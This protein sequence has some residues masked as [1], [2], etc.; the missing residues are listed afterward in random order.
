MSPLTQC[1]AWQDLINHRSEVSCLHLK[2]LFCN[3]PDRFRKFSFELNDI[4]IDLSK[5]LITDRTIELLIN[6]ARQLKLENQI[7]DLFSGKN[8][9]RS[10]SKPALH[11]ALRNLSERQVLVNGKNIM[12]EIHEQL[13]KIKNFVTDLHTGKWSGCTGEKITD[14]VNIG[15]GGSDLGPVMATQALQAYRNELNIHFISSIDGEQTAQVLEKLNP[16]TTLFIIV[17]KTFTTLDTM[18]NAKTIWQWFENKLGSEHAK[19]FIGIS[20]NPQAMAEFGIA[21]K[22]Q[23][24]FWD[25]VGGRYSIWSSCGLAIA[26]AT[27][28]DN[29]MDLLAGAYLVDQHIQKTPLEKNIPVLLGLL[30]VWYV[31]FFIVSSQVILPYDARLRRLPAYLQQLEMESCG[32]NTSQTGS[33][34]NYPT[35]TVTWGEIGTNG[36]HAFFQQ[37]H[38]GTQIIPADFIVPVDSHHDLENHHNLALANALAQSKALMQGKS[39]E[40]IQAVSENID[41]IQHRVYPGNR[42]NTT[43][44]FPKITPKTLGSLLAIY[45]HKVFVKSMIWNINPF[46]QWGVELGKQLAQ[47]ILPLLAGQKQSQ[48]E[49]DSSTQGLLNYVKMVRANANKN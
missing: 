4:L 7:Q 22:N 28:F 37:L 32:K 41:N 3:D 38:Q 13:N 47:E 34:I 42:P 29:F 48:Q 31:N 8:I 36:Q 20:A 49:L 10:E 24:L 43:L 19:H 6:L 46:D 12:P 16:A 23:F 21:T 44:L 5:N 15:V 45:E 27:S 33:K 1:Q 30:D 25:F 17:S 26:L 9:N 40:E 39:S 18:T 14:I 2:Q 35:G 11:T